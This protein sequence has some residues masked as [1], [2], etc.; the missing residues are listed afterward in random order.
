[1]SN[2]LQISTYTSS[3]LGTYFFSFFCAISMSFISCFFIV[4]K[5]FSSLSFF[6]LFF[7]S[8][9]CYS[10]SLLFCFLLFSLVIVCSWV[11]LM[12]KLTA[13]IDLYF[14]VL[15]AFLLFSSILFSLLFSSLSLF[16]NYC[17]FLGCFLINRQIDCRYWLVLHCFYV[18]FSEFVLFLFL[19]SLVLSLSFSSLVLNANLAFHLVRRN[20]KKCWKNFWKERSGKK[21]K[22]IIFLFH[23]LYLGLCDYYA[24]YH[25]LH[26][27]FKK[28]IF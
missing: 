11:E 12:V 5:C 27:S 19:L 8:P 14:I 2:W 25:D 10:S 17:L 24:Y 20:H 1:M 13:D 23:F 18:I 4:V 15:G 21:E 22:R 16:F 9:V 7:L 28:S 26:Q 3:F 6:V